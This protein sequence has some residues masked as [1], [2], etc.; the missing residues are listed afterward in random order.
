MSDY[1]DDSV[2]NN[3]RDSANGTFV[4]LDDVFPTYM[5]TGVDREQQVSVCNLLMASKICGV[6]IL[7][8]ALN[9]M[10]NTALNVEDVNKILLCFQ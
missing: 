6:R 2:T 5:I 8:G 1:D 7:T 3:L 4:T 9:M 10:T